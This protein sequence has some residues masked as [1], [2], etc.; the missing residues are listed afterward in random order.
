MPYPS[1]SHPSPGVL[2]K[3]SIT[4]TDGNAI[5]LDELVPDAEGE[6]D[7]SL[8]SEA[9]EV[10]EDDS[11]STETEAPEAEATQEQDAPKA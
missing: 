7:E 9:P 10:T 6:S 1:T 2:D 4:D 11:A 5:D 8:E 3:A